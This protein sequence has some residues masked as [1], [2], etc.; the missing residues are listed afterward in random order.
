MSKSNTEILAV[1][2]KS[3]N[4]YLKKNT[5]LDGGIKDRQL[6]PRLEDITSLI[7]SMLDYE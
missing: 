1:I 5:G 4:S 2:L 6:K 3:S 7:E